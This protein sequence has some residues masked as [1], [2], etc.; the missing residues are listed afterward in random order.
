MNSAIGYFKCIGGL[1]DHDKIKSYIE[2]RESWWRKEEECKNWQQN[3]TSENRARHWKTIGNKSRTE[4]VEAKYSKGC[5]KCTKKN[6]SN[7]PLIDKIFDLQKENQRYALE[8]KKKRYRVCW[9]NATES[10]NNDELCKKVRSLT[11]DLKTSESE[12]NHIKIKFTEQETKNKKIIS[13]LQQHNRLLDA[14]I[15]QLQ[16]GLCHQTKY[17]E[18]QNK[19]NESDENVFE[20]EKLIGHKKKKMACIFLFDGEIFHQ[21]TIHG[22]VNQI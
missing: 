11:A 3:N 6:Q 15:K 7:K 19:S 13:D 18:N 4:S 5:A 22:N 9:T 12:L 21:S 8:L 17:H 20:V 14:H 2:H 10:E 16:T 1:V